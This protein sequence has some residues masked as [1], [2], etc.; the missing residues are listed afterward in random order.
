MVVGLGGMNLWRTGVDMQ[1]WWGVSLVFVGI[2]VTVLGFTAW[3][4]DLTQ[5]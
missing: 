4:K 3:T 2:V 5:E 1:S